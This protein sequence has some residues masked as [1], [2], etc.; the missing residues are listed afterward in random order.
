MRKITKILGL[1]A[2]VAVAGTISWHALGETPM[3]G[4]PQGMGPGMMT[5]MGQGHGPMAGGFADPAA[6][7]AS[8]KTELGIT[9]QQQSAWDAYA[10]VVEDTAAS[11]KAQRQG[12]D[13]TAVHN[14]SD[15]DRQAFMTQMRD[16]QD[17]AFQSLKAAD[18]EFLA[19]LD[20]TQKAKAREVLPGLAAHGPGMMQHAGMGWHGMQPGSTTR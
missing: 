1:G 15:P 17:K 19:V 6:H 7:L 12:V 3:H 5:G 16:Q 20:D 9:P 14:M 13:M 2:A 11:M 8:L 10:K 18:G 4:G